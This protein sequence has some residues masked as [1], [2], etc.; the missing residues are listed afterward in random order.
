MGECCC[1]CRSRTFI[2]A[3]LPVFVF[4]S[5]CMF[6]LLLPLLLNCHE[7]QHLNKFLFLV[8]VE[9]CLTTAYGFLRTA[10]KEYDTRNE[11]KR[12][13]W[14]KKWKQN[15]TQ[16]NV[17][18]RSENRLLLVVIAPRN[19]AIKFWLWIFFLSLSLSSICFQFLL[20][21]NLI[22]CWIQLF[23]V[24]DSWT[25]CFCRFFFLILLQTCKIGITFSSVYFECCCCCFLFAFHLNK[26][27]THQTIFTVFFLFPPL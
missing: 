24:V 14:S 4:P 2:A 16:F 15:C 6:L 19:F 9:S 3:C 12:N 17:I 18:L 22:V 20:H 10:K 21:S 1:C 27:D 7:Q 25:Y 11:M 26:T 5:V 23:I 8:M 13:G